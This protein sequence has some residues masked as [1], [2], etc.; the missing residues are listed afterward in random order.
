MAE[1]IDERLDLTCSVVVVVVVLLFSN[2]FSASC[3]VPGNILNSDFLAREKLGPE[4]HFLNFFWS[5]LSYYSAGVNYFKSSFII[6][7]ILLGIQRVE[8]A[9]DSNVIFSSLL[10]VPKRV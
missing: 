4:G 10:T 6:I 1:S 9:L 3:F 8:E 5:L 7:I 2:F